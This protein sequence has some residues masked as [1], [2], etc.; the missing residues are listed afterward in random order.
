MIHNPLDKAMKIHCE[1]FVN[2]MLQIL[3]YDEII[4]FICPNE[5]IIK[6]N[7]YEADF[8]GYSNKNEIINIEFQSTKPTREDTSRFTKYA[9]ILNDKYKRDVRTIVI[10]TKD[11]EKKEIEHRIGPK[12]KHTITIETLKK[13]NGDDI[14]K[15]IEEKTNKKLSKKDISKL[16]LVPLMKTKDPTEQIILK[17]CKLTN[18]LKINPQDL[19]YLKCIQVQLSEKYVKDEQ[20][21]TL[22]KEEIKMKCKLFETVDQETKEKLLQQGRKEGE[23]EGRIKNSQKIALNLLKLNINIKDI[24]QATELTKEQIQTLQKQIPSK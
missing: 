10:S 11:P 7:E 6:N 17:V 15:K 16:S 18:K 2:Y 1:V 12:S 5:L 14:L 21:R 9:L 13:I 3:G 20:I 23:K 24:M 8:V 19:E 4:K 22:I